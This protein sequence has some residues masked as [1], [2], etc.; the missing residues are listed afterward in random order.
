[1][2]P[3]NVNRPP[4]VALLRSFIALLLSRGNSSQPSDFYAWRNDAGY[5][6]KRRRA[7]RSMCIMGS[8][9]LGRVRRFREPSAETRV[10]EP[11]AGGGSVG[12]AGLAP[13]EH[14]RPGCRCE[15]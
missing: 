1:D 3:G 10:I 12:A 6:A 4:S 7:M 11:R 9:C 8:G 14:G 5:V 13:R 2:V 15:C